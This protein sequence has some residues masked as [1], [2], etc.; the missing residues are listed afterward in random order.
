MSAIDLQPFC[1]TEAARF[2]LG[3]PFSIGD[4]TYATNGHIAVRVQRRA[5]VPVNPKAPDP[6]RVFQIDRPTFVPAQ[7]FEFPDLETVSCEK[8]GGQGHKHDCPS[9]ECVC[10]R[11]DGEGEH[12]SDV[13]KSGTIH[14]VPFNLR[15][16]RMIYALPDLE[17]PIALVPMEPMP[18]QFKGGDGVLMPLSHAMDENI[19]IPASAS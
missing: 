9:C 10:S 4:L 17:L 16:I 14:G 1:S 5:D 19:V 2:Y 12:L 15:Y 18:F 11:C 8:C 7:L 13:I 6:A 3:Q